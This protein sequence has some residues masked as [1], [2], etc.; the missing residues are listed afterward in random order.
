LD[1]NDRF[2]QVRLDRSG[3]ILYLSSRQSQFNHAIHCYPMPEAPEPLKGT[4]PK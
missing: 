3:S 4:H 1:L 2:G